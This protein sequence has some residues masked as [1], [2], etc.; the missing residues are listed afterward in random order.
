MWAGNTS[1]IPKGYL[2]CNGATLNTST[3]NK[4]YKAIGNQ[5]GGSG[6]NFKIPDLRDR[7]IVG[8]GSAYSVLVK[9]VV[10]TM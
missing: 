10:L 8:A 4:L 3:Y 5:W 7:F 6:G 2:L 1:N 9:P